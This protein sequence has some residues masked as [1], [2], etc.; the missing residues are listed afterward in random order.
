MR[1]VAGAAHPAVMRRRLFP[2]YLPPDGLRVTENSQRVGKHL[3]R[4]SEYTPA[5]SKEIGASTASTIQW[6]FPLNINVPVS[7]PALPYPISSYTPG[8]EFVRQLGQRILIMDGAM[9][10]MIQR[11]KLAE[12]DFRG[13]RFADHA[14]DV[15]ATT[16]CCRW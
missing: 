5:L 10:T 9:G 15:K 1:T 16:S 12:G 11:Y 14:R 4:R 6:G 8:A 13:T 2:V 3:F 7:Y